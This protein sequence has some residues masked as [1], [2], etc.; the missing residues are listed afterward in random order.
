MKRLLA[1]FAAFLFLARMSMPAQNAAYPGITGAGSPVGVV[2]CSASS[3]SGQLYTDNS[4]G[5]VWTC[6]PPTWQLPTKLMLTSAY[7]VSSNV[8]TN[9]TGLS[10]PVAVN[11]KY[12]LICNLVYQVSST[13]TIPQ[14]R[15]TGPTSPT[16]VSYSSLWQQT[17]NAA[18]VFTIGPAAAFSTTQGAAPTAATTNFTLLLHLGLINGAN[19]GTVQLQ[20]AASVSGSFT[21]QPTSWCAVQ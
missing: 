21:V 4:T 20:G 2:A 8:F 17:A 11:T 7:T 16:A 5:L 14:I 12:A 13:S 3:N 19:A 10:I 15:F 6:V 9:M 1:T 18:P